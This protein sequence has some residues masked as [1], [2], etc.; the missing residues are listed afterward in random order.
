MSRARRIYSP[1]GAAIKADRGGTP[2]ALGG[3]PVASIRE[4]WVV[5]D[6]WWTERPLHRH[7][8]ELALA[9][10]RNVTVFRDVGSGRWQ[11][12]PA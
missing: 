6:R 10:G 11:R 12:Q 3:M 4:E 2:L 7:Y 1:Q 8:Y 9:D 5:Q